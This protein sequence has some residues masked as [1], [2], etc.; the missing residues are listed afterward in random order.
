[1]KRALRS[2]GASQRRVRR[3]VAPPTDPNATHG[4]AAICRRDSANLVAGDRK[5]KDTDALLIDEPNIIAT[6]MA[7]LD[8]L[9]TDEA[10]LWRSMSKANPNGNDYAKLR[11]SH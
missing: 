6:K 5:K 1:M 7:A 11:K 10:K 4:N 2:G 3:P 8:K 9:E